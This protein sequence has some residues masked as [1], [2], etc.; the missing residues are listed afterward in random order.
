MAL[1]WER[2]DKPVTVEVE[3]LCSEE[4]EVM[5]IKPEGTYHKENDEIIVEERRRT[6]I[7]GKLRVKKDGS[8]V[9][10]NPGDP[11]DASCE[12]GI[13]LYAAP[14]VKPYR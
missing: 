1:R 2:R 13:V 8:V 5:I 12:C 11:D 14:I 6:Y 4:D 3:R 10:T 7:S 9:V